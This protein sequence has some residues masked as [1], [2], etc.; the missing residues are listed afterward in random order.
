MEDKLI[1]EAIVESPAEYFGKPVT[2]DSIYTRVRQGHKKTWTKK[3]IKPRLGLVIGT[4][5]LRNGTVYYY[6]DHTEWNPIG[7]A[8]PCILVVFTPR[9]NVARI[10]IES[11]RS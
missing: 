11:V 3:S 2:A 7:D 8:F 1:G 6:E 10:P 9:E 4:R 5:W